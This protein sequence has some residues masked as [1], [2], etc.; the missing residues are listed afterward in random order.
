MVAA[1]RA[2]TSPAPIPP[3]PSIA[4]AIRGGAITPQAAWKRC[5]GDPAATGRAKAARLAPGDTVLFKGDGWG[6]GKAVIDG[7]TVLEANWTRCTSADELRGNRNFAKVFFAAAPKGY[8]FLAGTYEGSEFLY[9]CQ[10][11][12]PSDPFNYDRVDQLRVLP[13]KSGGAS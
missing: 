1:Y 7:G 10:D 3:M 12:P 8:N 2:A 13:A 6:E 11:P 5:P 9:P 4:I